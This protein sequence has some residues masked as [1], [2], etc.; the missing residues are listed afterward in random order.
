MLLPKNA[1]TPRHTQAKNNNNKYI[2]SSI[3]SKSDLDSDSDFDLDCH[4]SLDNNQS[5]SSNNKQQ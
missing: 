2:L 4:N 1:H 5:N 3:D